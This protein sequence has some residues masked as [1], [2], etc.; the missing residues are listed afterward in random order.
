MREPQVTLVIVPRER[1]SVTERSLKNVYEYTTYPFELVY[2][3]GGTTNRFKSYLENESRRRHFKFIHTDRYLSPN[4]ARNLALPHVKS[5]Y[6]VF[7]ENDVLV[8]PGWLEALVGCAEETGAWVVGPLYLLG[9]LELQTIHMAGGTLNMMEHQG[10]RILHD[11]HRF[12]DTPIS[13]L[14]APLE[15]GTCD[16]VEF[17]CMLVRTDVFERLG[18]LDE[19]LLSIHEH[20]DLA[21]AVSRSGGAV[22]VEPNAKATYIPPPPGEWFD[23]PYIMIRWGD[24]WNLSSVGHFK[25]KWGVSALR[26]FNDTADLGLEDT[27]V[28][29]ARAHRRLMTG[30]HVSSKTLADQPWSVVEE[31][32]FLIATFSSVDRDSFDLMLTDEGGRAVESVSALSLP[33]LIERLPQLLDPEVENLNVVIRPIAHEAV[34][35]PALIR[36]DDLGAD[37][38]DAI[39]PYAFL[40]LEVAPQNYQCWL[41]VAKPPGL[42]TAALGRHLGIAES[43]SETNG[44]V[45]LAGS[46]NM[47]EEVRQADGSYPRVKLVE[48]RIGLL[49]KVKQ[50]EKDGMTP[51][52]SHGHIS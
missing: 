51:C 29:W 45:R 38:I 32:E 5:K 43:M 31:A 44:A 21:M 47:S 20:I 22:Y 34:N 30:L 52:L 8:T 36:L 15:R 27:I 14:T 2:V 10:K 39:L 16:Y 17:H 40:T 33:A 1:F 13:E 18:P 26:F 25:E 28:R 46:R 19:K 9:E 42:S 49:N 23:L 12:V 6:V 48:A 11:E 35:T 24:A 37:E 7:L 3:S 50:L 41:A 4:Q